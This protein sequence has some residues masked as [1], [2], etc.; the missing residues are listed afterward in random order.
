MTSTGLG[1]LNPPTFW[2]FQVAK[3]HSSLK[4]QVCFRA[5]LSIVGSLKK[6]LK[7][8]NKLSHCEDD[9]EGTQSFNGAGSNEACD[10]AKN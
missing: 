3:C 6:A 1:T 2:Y 8:E 5:E 4:G 7:V 9:N 10:Y